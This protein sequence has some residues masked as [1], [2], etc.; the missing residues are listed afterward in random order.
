MKQIFTRTIFA[1]LT[2]LLLFSFMPRVY[3]QESTSPQPVQTQQSEEKKIIF[4]YGQGCPH[5]A[6]VEAWFQKEGI[7]DQYPIEAKEIYFNKDNTAE[8]NATME[9]LGVPVNERG[10]PTIIIGDVRLVGD[11][12]IIEGFREAADAYMGTVVVKTEK[13]IE[14]QPVATDDETEEDSS[15]LS[16]WMVISA[17]AVDAINPCAFAVLVILLSTVLTKK[18]KKK[19]LFSGL[20]FTGAIFISYILMGLG[21]YA[22][23][24]SIGIASTITKVVGGLAIVL[25]LL[26]LKNYFWYDKGGLIEVPQSWRPKMTKI[27]E[28][29]TSPSGA[30]AIGFLVSLFLLPCTSGPYIVILGLLAKNSFDAG[31]IAYLL[32]Y[33][34]IFILP[35]FLITLFVYKGLDP[36]RVERLRQE[37]LE[38][39]HLITGII[40]IV[41][42]VFVLVT[43]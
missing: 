29:V 34:F 33:N 35:M 6:K 16:L 1:A 28:S 27:I 17:S 32:L 30:M 2:L 38:R 42:G 14:D 36:Q 7:Y 10:V 15:V 21:V 3:A 4:F 22:A 41:I 9:K 12:P 24:G 23:L 18:D 43:S 19:A 13:P 31:A 11:E 20:A 26:N 40:L 37:N 8:F 39:L 25:G 5:C